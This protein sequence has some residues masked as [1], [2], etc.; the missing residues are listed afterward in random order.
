MSTLES[1]GTKEQN[2][3]GQHKINVSVRYVTYNGLQHLQLMN[4]YMYVLIWLP[5]GMCQI[6]ICKHYCI[7]RG[8]LVNTIIIKAQGPIKVTQMPIN[9]YVHIIKVHR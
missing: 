8:T 5:V 6:N 1:K 4:T 9:Q 7:I 2:N 3:T